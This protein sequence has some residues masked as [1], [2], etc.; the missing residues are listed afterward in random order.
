MWGWL[1]AHR[2]QTAKKKH[3]PNLLPVLEV[4]LE[5][6]TAMHLVWV[7]SFAVIY[8]PGI[9]GYHRT[10]SAVPCTLCHTLYSVTVLSNNTHEKTKKKRLSDVSVPQNWP[11]WAHSV[12][13][14]R[15]RHQIRDW[16]ES[17][18]SRELLTPG[19][20]DSCQPRGLVTRDFSAIF[21]R[22]FDRLPVRIST[23]DLHHWNLRKKI[24]H[25]RA[26]DFGVQ[27][28]FNHSHQHS[29]RHSNYRNSTS[30]ERLGKPNIRFGSG[31]T[32]SKIVSKFRLT[33]NRKL[34]SAN[35][36]TIYHTIACP[37][38]LLWCQA[39]ENR[40]PCVPKKCSFSNCASA[41]DSFCPVLDHWWSH[42]QYL[43]PRIHS[44]MTAMFLPK[45]S[46][47]SKK[48]HRQ[49]SWMEASIWPC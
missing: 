34:R 42:G 8:Q 36:N 3:H 20:S 27:V 13:H 10:S 35:R 26:Y 4:A 38:L 16:S 39:V 2:R 49:P 45:N 25:I 23:S 43:L 30:L 22:L 31:R 29:M 12:S 28:S 37:E 11:R 32:G 46:C 19:T 24:F 41:R 33:H 47:R 15:A 6:R 17:G 1:L 44:L 7:A 40:G 5:Q 18:R 14:G 21:D 9:W 48:V